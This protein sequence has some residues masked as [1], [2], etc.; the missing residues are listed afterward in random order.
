MFNCHKVL[1]FLSPKKLKSTTLMEYVAT[2]QNYIIDKKETFIVE[3][4][5]E[6]FLKQYNDSFL[7]SFF[8]E[9]PSARGDDDHRIDLIPCSVPPNRP[10]YHIS[11]TKQEEIMSKVHE[12]LDKGLVHPSLLRCQALHHDMASTTGLGHY[13]TYSLAN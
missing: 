12:L 11:R 7:N 13:C 6:E 1:V 9:L 5:Q 10:P 4:V 3:K 2:L 8:F